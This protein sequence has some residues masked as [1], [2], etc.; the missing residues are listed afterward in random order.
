VVVRLKEPYSPIIPYFFGGDSNYTILPAHLLAR[1]RSLD[2]VAYNAAPIGSGPYRV[3]SWR[4]EDR[5]ELEANPRYYGGM[6]AIRR[7]VLRTIPD[8][9]TALNQLT[10]GE[11]DAYFRAD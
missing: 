7:I 2:H 11:V 3:T 9:Q 6:P 4:H 5:I 1:Y 8:P 10:T